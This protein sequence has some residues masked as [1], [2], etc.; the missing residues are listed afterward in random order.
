MPRSRLHPAIVVTA[1]V[2]AGPLSAAPVEAPDLRLPI[3]VHLLRADDAPVLP[4]AEAERFVVEV[5]RLYAP[6]N[7][8]FALQE[9]RD[10]DVDADLE[11]VRD[12]VALR[13]HLVPRAINVFL[14]R[15]MRD[16]EPDITTVRA[17]ARVGREPSGW[18]N[19]AQVTAPGQIPA[20]YLIVRAGTGPT[21]L[22]HELGHLLGEGHHA[23]EG[24]IMSYGLD[25]HDFDAAQL[26]TF[27]ALA[28]RE[29]QHGLPASDLCGV[30]PAK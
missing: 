1:C 23:G 9:I 18:L 15:S 7:L 29:L 4:R 8:C 17:A 22:A 2:L 26:R 13:A 10:L 20:T 21:T 6:A 28:R 3:V 12:R 16:P 5:N 30:P 19:G 25:R 14:V 24:N 11:T 27:R